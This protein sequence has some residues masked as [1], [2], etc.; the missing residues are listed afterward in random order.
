MARDAEAALRR[1][2]DRRSRRARLHRDAAARPAGAA[3]PRRAVPAPRARPVRS[4][5]LLAGVARRSRSPAPPA[6]TRPRCASTY[7]V[8]GGFTDAHGARTRRGPARSGSR[9][10]MATSSIDGGA[11]VVLLRRRHRH[12][13]VHRLSRGPDRR[14]RRSPS[15]LAY[16]ART[17]RAADLPG[18]RRALRA[19]R[20][21]ARRVVF[22]RARAD[23][24]PD[25]R[26]R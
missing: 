23:G 12:H 3:V 11:D 15:T 26:R 25:P 20:A 8:T 1:R 19:A 17:E 14:R 18:P 2:A 21:V 13:G 6:R 5:G 7:A 22:R 10:R 9:C 16:G 4:D 24:E